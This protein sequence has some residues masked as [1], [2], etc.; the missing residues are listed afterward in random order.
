[1][2][3]NKSSSASNERTEN[4]RLVI[5]TWNCTRTGVTYYIQLVQFLPS[6]LPTRDLSQRANLLL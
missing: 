2:F 6:Y 3:L 5:E 4:T 1:M